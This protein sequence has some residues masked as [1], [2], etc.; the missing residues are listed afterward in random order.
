MAENLGLGDVIAKITEK[1]GIKKV[2]DTVTEALD[3]D[4]GC[5][6]RQEKMNIIPTPFK[7]K[8]R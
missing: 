3:I 8:D 2:V 5:E 7:K 4:C 1:T 6:A